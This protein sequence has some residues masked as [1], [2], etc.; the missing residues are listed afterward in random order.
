VEILRTISFYIK[1]KDKPFVVIGGHALNALGLN[2]HTGDIDLLVRS[3][4]RDFWIKLLEELRYE[5]G[6]IDKYFARFRAKDYSSWPVDLMFVDSTTFDNFYSKAKLVDFGLSE[7]LVVSAE[8]L[9][10]SKMNAVKSYQERIP[11]DTLPEYLDFDLPDWSGQSEEQSL[12]FK[13]MILLCEKMLPIW[14]KERF[15]YPP[16]PMWTEPFVLHD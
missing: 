5:T 4:D 1:G 8:H 11:A 2:R 15:Q 12:S 6:Q 9:I 16:P 14:N 3:D 10:A 13:E 7:A